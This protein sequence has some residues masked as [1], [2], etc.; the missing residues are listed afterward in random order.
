[1]IGFVGKQALVIIGAYIDRRTGS[2][3]IRV[4]M[5]VC[6]GVVVHVLYAC[7]LYE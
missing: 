3:E 1:M 7:L 4:R 5:F 2:S 6:I